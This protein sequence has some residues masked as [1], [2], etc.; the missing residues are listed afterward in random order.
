MRFIMGPKFL[1][2]F[3]LLL[4][5][6]T[7]SAQTQICFDSCFTTGSI[8]VDFVLAG[9]HESTEIYLDEIRYEPFWG[10][11][12]QNM[13]DPFEYGE[14][15]FEIRRE[16]DGKLI[17]SRGFC[18]LYE[19]WQTTAEAESIRRAF[20]QV[21]LFPT[22]KDPF[23]LEI[24][25]RDGQNQFQVKYELHI[26]PDDPYIK[27]GLTREF[28][29]EK[30]VDN[31]NPEERLDL[32]FVAEGYTHEEVEQF[33]EDV[34]KF[35][36]YLFGVVPFNQAQD[37]FNVWAVASTSP[38]SGVDLPGESVWKKTVM[39]ANFYT[40]GSKRYLTTEDIKSVR[41]IAGNVPYD[42]ICVLVNTLEYGGG[43][44]Y[45]H[46]CMASSGGRTAGI[47]FVHELGHALAGLGDEYYSSSVAYEGFFNLSIEPWQPNLTTL[48]D[49]DSK[50]KDLLSDIIPVPTPNLQEYAGKTGVFEGG[51]YLAEG[52]YRPALDCWMKSNDAT[53]FCEVCKH[54]IQKM[55]DYHCGK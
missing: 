42:V 6:N 9:D 38:D 45:N 3:A 35:S 24:F 55:I 50:W 4:I 16:V 36:D 43:G 53:E 12:H 29:F 32:V 1:L 46:Y 23:L 8:R 14:Y 51:G 15:K 5:I 21:I 44:I 52:I 41:D 2:Y 18:T 54:A 22:P 30:L 10:G 13:I 19:E 7:L 40:F 20:D 47:V 27:K 31:G 49:F 34:R 26:D 28:S 37:Q 17:F 11:P 25:G 33:Y 48:V 39:N